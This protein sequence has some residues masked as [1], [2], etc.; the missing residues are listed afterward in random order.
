MYYDIIISLHVYVPSASRGQDMSQRG[1][2]P[3]RI[4]SNTAPRQTK[5]IMIAIMSIITCSSNDNSD[6][7]N[8]SS[9]SSSN[10]DDSSNTNHNF[11]LRPDRIAFNTVRTVS[12][13]YSIA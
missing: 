3:D 2:R 9:S 11:V 13:E 12:I 5:A 6:N 1:L 4:A 10:H 8:S 7:D